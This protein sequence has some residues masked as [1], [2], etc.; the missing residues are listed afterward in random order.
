MTTY[1]IT[2]H[3]PSTWN[4]PVPVRLACGTF[5][6][7]RRRADAAM[8][9]FNREVDAMVR[10]HAALDTKAGTDAQ[11]FARR[12]AAPK[13]HEGAVRITHGGETVMIEAL[14]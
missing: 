4:L 8:L 11:W 12:A 1:L 3:R 7:E 13:P 10:D 2:R 6:A 5:Q 14:A 9:L